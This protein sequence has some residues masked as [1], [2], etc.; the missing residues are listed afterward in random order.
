MSRSLFSGKSLLALGAAAGLL[1]WAAVRRQ[2]ASSLSGEVAIVTG[3]SRGLGFLLARELVREGC[4]VAI[5]ARDAE[6]LAEAEKHLSGE[7]GQV[8]TLTCDV[9]ER[10]QVRDLVQEVTQRWGRVDILVNNAGVIQ[11]G[12]V[13]T[14]SLEAFQSAM[15]IMFWGPLHAIQAVLPQMLER[16]S[17]RIANITSIGGKVS[18]PHL[19]PYNCAKFAAVGLSEGLR[20]ELSKE[21][22]SITTV[23]PGLMRTGS[24]L[25]AYFDGR[26]EEEFAWFALASTLPLLTMNAER[27]ARKIVRAVKRSEAE[28]IISLPAFLLTRF[29]GLMPGTTTRILSLANRFLPGTPED[30]MEP[31]IGREL[32]GRIDS[33]LFH[34]ATSLGT[35][36]ARKF[37]FETGTTLKE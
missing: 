14:M 1:A 28:A 22:I 9:G 37:Q 11:A 7:G 15:D 34:K 13:E 20:A 2:R 19:L 33:S 18:V 23:V 31:G 29:H 3:G 30:K 26:Q 36:A 6:E 25:N 8:L 16:K 12:P 5:C 35:E 10:R 24:Y 21:G 27:A 32:Q 17:G 4:R